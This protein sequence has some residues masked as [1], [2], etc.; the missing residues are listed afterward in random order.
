MNDTIHYDNSSSLPHAQYYVNQLYEPQ[1]YLLGPSTQQGTEVSRTEFFM[2]Q[3]PSLPCPIVPGP[4]VPA[5]TFDTM[6]TGDSAGQSSYTDLGQSVSP[7][8]VSPTAPPTQPSP[9]RPAPVVPARPEQ[10][11]SHVA[12]S[13]VSNQPRLVILHIIV[14]YGGVEV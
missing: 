3:Q 1:P 4:I 13:Q 8:L 6:Y 5:V 2:L 12:P 9:V 11:E 10:Q 14:M 7:R